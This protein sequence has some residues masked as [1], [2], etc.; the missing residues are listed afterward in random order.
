MSGKYDVAREGF[1]DGTISWTKD[2]IVAQLV[3]REYVFDPKHKDARTLKGALGAPLTLS[4]KSI[5]GGWA[6]AD[7]MIF[8][9]MPG[10]GQIEVVAMVIRRDAKEENRKTLIVHLTDIEKFPM[11]PNGGDILIDVPASGLFRI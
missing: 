10:D 2:K 8:K 6:K 9:E 5:P 4:G 7:N 11:K 3:T 1:G